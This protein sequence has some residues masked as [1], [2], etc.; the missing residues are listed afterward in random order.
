MSLPVFPPGPLA[1]R[2]QML[3][4]VLRNMD[5]V[6]VAVSGGVD[7]LTLASFAQRVM[8][9]LKGD[10]TSDDLCI[11]RHRNLCEHLASLRQYALR[12]R[13]LTS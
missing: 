3:Q 11:G 10:T 8:G 7:S 6:A 2:A 5:E 9:L 4:S 13:V 1:E 12:I